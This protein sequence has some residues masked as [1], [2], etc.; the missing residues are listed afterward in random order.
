MTAEKKIAHHRLTLL[1]VAERIRNVS[2]ACRHHGISRSQFY[3]YKRA[4]QERGFDGLVDRPP[5]PKNSPNETPPECREKVIAL[6]IK[7]PSWGPMKISDQLRL[8]NVSVSPSTVRNIWIKESMETR[9][10][11]LLR[12][13]EEK[14]D[15]ELTEEQIRLLEKANPCFRERHVESPYPGYLLCQDTFMVGS[16]KGIGRVYLQAVVDTYGSYAFGKLYTSKL[17]ETAADV[18]YDRVLP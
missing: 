11:R 12:M 6:S 4:F 15:V 17:P 8:E 5:I 1:Q 7:H 16:L 14:G 2:E 18:L 3:E 9:Y 13:E 10:K